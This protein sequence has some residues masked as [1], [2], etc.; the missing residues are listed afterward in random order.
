MVYSCA[1]TI[2]TICVLTLASAAHGR[3]TIEPFT[4]EPALDVPWVADPSNEA[5]SESA[6]L[7]EAASPSGDVNLRGWIGVDQ[8]GLRLRVETDDEVHINDQSESAIW[9]GDFLR[10]SI[11]ARADGPGK[12]ARDTAGIF[13]PDDSTIGFALTSNGP[14]GWTYESGIPGQRGA[15]PVELLSF[16][17]DES[18]KLTRYDLRLP[19]ERLGVRPGAFPQMGI[20]VQVRDIDSPGQQDAPHARW[21]E[22]ADGPRPGLF[23]RIN[24]PSPPHAIIEATPTHAEIWAP[25]DAAEIVVAVRADTD[26]VIRASA[27]EEAAELAVPGSASGSI[28]HYAVR[29]VPDGAAAARVDVTVAPRG[30]GDAV[31]RVSADVVAPGQVVQRLVDRLDAL[32]VSAEHPLFARHLRS[33]KAIVQAEWARATLYTPTNLAEARATLHR[34]RQLLAGF[35]SDAAEWSSYL[36]RGMPLFMA[37][38]SRRDG[39]LQYYS[40]VLPRGFDA[41]LS[42]EEQPA[43][44]MYLELHGAGDPSPI[45]WPAGVLGGSLDGTPPT[46][47]TTYAMIRRT[48][49]HVFPFGRGNSGYRDIGEVDVWEAYDDVHE[50]VKIDPDRRYLYGFSMGGRGTWALGSRTPD[51]WAAIAIMG[52]GVNAGDYGLADNVASLPIYVWGGANDAVAFRGPGTPREQIE[53]FAAALRSVGNEPVVSISEGVGHNYLGEVQQA[54]FE[55]MSE[56]RRQRPSEFRFVADT[57]RHRGVWGIRLRRDIAVSSLPRLHCVVDGQRI[58][59]DT[60]G[61]QALELDLGAEG[62]G[63]SGDVTVIWNGKEAYAGPVNG[64]PRRPIRL[65]LEETQ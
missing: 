12:G 34:I 33:V 57:E 45:A 15:Y 35:E 60:E 3:L 50:T 13:G 28:G 4:V 38:L 41:S 14:A 53:R 44:P 29:Y 51:R 23:Q 39:T 64:S 2:A 46:R 40:L 11:D 5:W 7:F 37:Y 47:P 42:R 55:W 25:G 9:N 65:N 48:G 17:R 18:R 43:Y 10:V 30:S 62:L 61:T 58:T 24:L 19:W 8:D 16:S 54:T 1:V 31:A 27:G 59:I 32:L 26:H 22:G 6:P 20:A 36:E 56:H 63:L 21:G 52:M 49:F